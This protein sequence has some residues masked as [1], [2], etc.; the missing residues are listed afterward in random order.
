MENIFKLTLFT[1]L[2]VFTLCSNTYCQIFH[3]NEKDNPEISLEN[4]MNAR[5]NGVRLKDIRYPDEFFDCLKPLGEPKEKDHKTYYGVGETITFKY[6]GFEIRY[7]AMSQ[8]EFVLTGI[9]FYG[10][11]G[12]KIDNENT[13]RPGNPIESYI[14]NAE[15]AGLNFN[16]RE[17][18]TVDV[19][20]DDG[21]RILIDLEDGPIFFLFILNKKRA[22]MPRQ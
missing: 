14:K 11:V 3:I 12:L 7:G 16:N 20:E 15:F 6:I 17:K 4:F 10:S 9:E 18:I 22:I 2:I 5:L 21:V 19:P 8:P 1:L 13:L